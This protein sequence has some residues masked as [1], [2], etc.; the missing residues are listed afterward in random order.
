MVKSLER[1]IGSFD[2]P[3]NGIFMSLPLDFVKGIHQF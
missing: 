3:G 2:E 1:M